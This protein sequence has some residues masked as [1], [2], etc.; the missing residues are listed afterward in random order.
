MENIEQNELNQEEVVVYD[1]ETTDLPD[2]KNKSDGENQPHLVSLTAIRCNKETGEEIQRISLIVASEGWESTEKAFERHRITKEYSQK[3]GLPEAFIV[4][5]FLDLCR[6]CSTV[7]QNWYFDYRMIRIQLKRYGFSQDVIDGWKDKTHECTMKMAKPIMELPPFNKRWGWKNPNLTEAYKY[8]T[9]KD[10]GE[11]AHNSRFDAEACREIYFAI[12][13]LEKKSVVD[14]EFDDLK[15][16]TA[17]FKHDPLPD[18]DLETD[19]GIEF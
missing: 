1:T 14:A 18:P 12:R 17:N 7:A 8:F 16:E 6:G 13:K 9:G 3:V 11:E 19:D 4:Q 2:W 15:T 10:L 5:T